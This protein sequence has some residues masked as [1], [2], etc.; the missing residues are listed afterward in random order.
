MTIHVTTE[1]TKQITTPS[2]NPVTKLDHNQM[3]T[4]GGDPIENRGNILEETLQ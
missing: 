4:S 3:T 2:D 1:V